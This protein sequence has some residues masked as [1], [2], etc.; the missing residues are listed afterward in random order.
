[1]PEVPERSL[2]SWSWFEY[3]QQ[4]FLHTGSRFWLYIFILKVQRTSRSIKSSFRALEDTGG[5][6]WGLA[7]WFWFGYGHWSLIHPCSEFFLSV[8][9]LKVQRTSR[10]IKSWYAILVGV[11]G[12]W[13]GI[14]TGHWYTHVPNFGSLSWFWNC[15]EHPCPLSSDLGLWRMPEVP[16]CGLASFL[17]L[18]Y[19][20][21]LFPILI[22]QLSSLKLKYRVIYYKIGCL[23]IKFEQDLCRF[24]F[25]CAICYL[26]VRVSFCVLWCRPCSGLLH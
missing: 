2:G 22:C 25:V 11:R 19:L 26:F 17:I 13:L 4:S 24:L 12:S 5:P 1:M 6:D 10:S 23:F 8:L 21:Y 18:S 14:G 7:S 20:I 9:I 15:K 3:G 16:D